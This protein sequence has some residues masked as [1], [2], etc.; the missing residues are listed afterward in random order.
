M[1]GRNFHYVQI[2]DNRPIV[3]RLSAG[4]RFSAS[5]TQFTL[6]GTS[7][8]KTLLTLGVPDIFNSNDTKPDD[9]SPNGEFIAVTSPTQLT[10][11]PTILVRANQGFG[12]GI[13]SINFPDNTTILTLLDNV[14]S[15]VQ[16]GDT[17]K[18]TITWTVQQAQSNQ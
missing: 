16:P 7:G 5:A 8:A 9:K 2:D 18:S 15:I 17:Y 10:S 12:Y 13:T 14:A 6:N 4:W 11:N 1:A 3:N